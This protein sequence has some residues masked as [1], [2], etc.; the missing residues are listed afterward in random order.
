M[1]SRSEG[2]VP[3]I[4]VIL[5]LWNII[6]LGCP[7]NGVYYNEL[8]VLVEVYWLLLVYINEKVMISVL[9]GKR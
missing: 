2:T 5:Q 4:I 8:C 7:S 6:C 1:T 3:L 9:R